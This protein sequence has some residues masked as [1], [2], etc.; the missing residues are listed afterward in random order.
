MIQPIDLMNIKQ[1][2]NN[3]EYEIWFN[4]HI[5]LIMQIEKFLRNTGRNDILSKIRTSIEW[6]SRFRSFPLFVQ[7]EILKHEIHN[8]L[9]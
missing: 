4:D 7:G 5:N 6:H 3:I 2:R 8:S 9:A 1:I